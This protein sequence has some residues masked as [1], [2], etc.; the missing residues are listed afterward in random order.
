MHDCNSLIFFFLLHTK[1]SEKQVCLRTQK[2]MQTF[3]PNLTLEPSHLHQ[4]FLPLLGAQPSPSSPGHHISTFLAFLEVTGGRKKCDTSA[5]QD[6]GSSRP[7]ALGSCR[8]KG[9]AKLWVVLREI[10]KTV[11][12]AFSPSATLIPAPESC[13]Q[14]PSEEASHSVTSQLLYQVMSAHHC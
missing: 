12:Q 8:R 6:S 3:A 1:L 14:N 2:R 4:S 5:E 10:R 7:D 13:V 11:S 9:R